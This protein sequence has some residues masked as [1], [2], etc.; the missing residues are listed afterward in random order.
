MDREQF[1]LVADILGVVTGVMA[2]LGVSGLLGWSVFDRRKSLLSDW[3]LLVAG[4]S[5]KTAVCVAL[6]FGFF[7][8]F[9]LLTPLIAA[10]FGDAKHRDLQAAVV[11]GNLPHT[12]GALVAGLLLAPVWAV[13]C[14]CVYSSS[15]APIQRFVKILTRTRY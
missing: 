4:Y 6:S 5:V 9:W 8:L 14:T 15:L 3:V 7:Q 13:L 12:V 10:L 11:A 1:S 2:L